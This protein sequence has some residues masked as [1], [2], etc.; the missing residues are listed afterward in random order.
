MYSF[1]I[2]KF[3]CSLCSCNF[4]SWP[5]FDTHFLF[6]ANYHNKL[7][8]RKKSNIC[9]NDLTHLGWE[10][11]VVVC[12]GWFSGRCCCP[13]LIPYW[14]GLVSLRNRA[15]S[16]HYPFSPQQ[17]YVA[18]RVISVMGNT[19]NHCE[20][21]ISFQPGWFLPNHSTKRSAFLNSICVFAYWC[22]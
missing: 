18:D 19:R 16:A 10:L 5:F 1:I 9:L 3:I 13:I 2:F 11:V 4:H 17:G 8:A 14:F 22:P 6:G 20:V 12:Y 21:D 15:N 7:P